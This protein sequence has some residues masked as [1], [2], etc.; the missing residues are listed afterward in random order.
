MDGSA[1]PSYMKVRSKGLLYLTMKTE[2]KMA[3]A[4]KL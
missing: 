4:G 3:V 1:I 2:I